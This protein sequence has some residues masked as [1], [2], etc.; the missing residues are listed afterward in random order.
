[1]KKVLVYADTVREARRFYPEREGVAVG[2]RLASEFT[3]PEKADEVLFVREYPEIE[4]AYFLKG[5]KNG[6]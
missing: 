4:N 5:E 6:K 3:K 2:Y 1:M